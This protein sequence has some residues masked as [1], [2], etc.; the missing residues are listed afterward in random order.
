MNGSWVTTGKV[1]ST[2]PAVGCWPIC[3]APKRA[4]WLAI[5]FLMSVVV[6]PREAMRSGF[7]QIRMAWSG[8][9]MIEAWPAPGTRLIASRT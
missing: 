5:D 9:P 6:I 8:T 3:P 2:R 1:S 4:F 7:I